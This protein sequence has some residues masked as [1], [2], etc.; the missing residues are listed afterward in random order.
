[1]K[2]HEQLRQLQAEFRSLCQSTQKS[3]Q[4]HFQLETLLRKTIA[5]QEIK[6][7]QLTTEN[8]KVKEEY[9][10]EK[11]KVKVFSKKFHQLYKK[12]HY[13]KSDSNENKNFLPNSILPITPESYDNMVKL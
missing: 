11:E 1:M 13:M 9:I 8:Q 3:Q 4:D 10:L 7:E 5:S 12:S 2:K 6:I